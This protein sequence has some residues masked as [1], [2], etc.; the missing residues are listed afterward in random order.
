MDTTDINNTTPK[1]NGKAISRAF[2]MEGELAEL[3]VPLSTPVK[4]LLMPPLEPPAK[5]PVTRQT[6]NAIQ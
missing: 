6:R 5:K 2:C 3:R 4:L 1:I